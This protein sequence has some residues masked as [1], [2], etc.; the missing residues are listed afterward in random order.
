[1][2][3]WKIYLGNGEISIFREEMMKVEE[4][5]TDRSDEFAW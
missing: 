4:K 3:Q 2:L 5:D 1:V